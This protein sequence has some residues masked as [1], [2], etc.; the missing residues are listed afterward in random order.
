MCIRDSPKKAALG[1]TTT[2]NAGLIGTVFTVGRKVGDASATYRYGY[3]ED[4]GGPVQTGGTLA[5]GIQTNGEGYG[6]PSSSS[7]S[8]Y[9]ITGQG[10]G[11]KLGVTV[12]TGNSGITA[13]TIQDDGQGYKVGD[14]VGIVT[15][16]MSGAGSGVRIG[17]NSLSGIDTLYLTNIQA[18]EFTNAAS[19]NYFHDLGTV[20]DSGLDVTRY[21]ETGSIYTG[22]YARVSYFNHGM[23]GT[24]NKVAISGAAPDTLPTVT[25]TTINSTTSSI[26]IGDSTGFDVFEGVLVSA[27][28]TAYAIINNEVISYTSVGINTLSG[29]VRGVDNTQPINHES[30]SPIQKYELAG[31]G[32]S[33]INKTH[34]VSTIG[35]N[36]LLYTSPS[37]RDS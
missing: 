16:E 1:I 31:V 22:E 23:Y 28:N 32:L 12:G 24:G 27:A 17:I 25:S 13:L 37:P 14:I 26:A 7:V 20:I 19:V 3:I 30:G 34:D 4:V 36:C 11:L 18:E 8:T 33:K 29:I 15:A 6:T 9:A 21:D 35:R 10:A 2:T 5:V